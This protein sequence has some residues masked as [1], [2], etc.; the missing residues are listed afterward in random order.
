[1]YSLCRRERSRE[2]KKTRVADEK[3]LDDEQGKLELNWRD[4][5][6]PA[7]VGLCGERKPIG[8]STL[9]TKV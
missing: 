5:I 7:R 2:R 8:S 3:L 4:G 1:M 9:L 6:S